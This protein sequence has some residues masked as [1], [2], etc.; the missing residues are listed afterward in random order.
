MVDLFEI[1]FDDAEKFLD[2]LRPSKK[3]WETSGWNKLWFFRGQS[4]PL[5][6]NGQERWKLIPSVWRSNP[7]F[8]D[9]RGYW[10]NDS[11]AVQYLYKR[12]Q[13][14]LFTKA[15]D[16]LNRVS[17]EFNIVDDFVKL[18]D[19][20]GF[21][22]PRLDEWIEYRKDLLMDYAKNILNDVTSK[23]WLHPIVALAQHHGIPTRLLDWTEN[24]FVA[25]Y[26]ALNSYEISK[27]DDKDINK[28][29]VVYAVNIYNLAD[30]FLL[31]LIPDMQK[32][33][34]LTLSK[35]ENQNLR[36]QEG[37]F[38]LYKNADK[39]FIQNGKFP[40]FNDVFRY[41]AT[42][43]QV[44]H[45]FDMDDNSEDFLLLLKYPYRKITLS[46]ENNEQIFELKRLLTHENYTQ[47]HLMPS[48]DNVASAVKSRLNIR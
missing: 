2:Y 18:A 39:Y 27:Q 41:N 26:F 30:D 35:A 13:D 11:Q 36:M 19:A 9:Y 43:L 29:I 16:L 40:N 6:E 47:A 28:Q 1:H 17:Y 22:L 33:Q 24:P 31:P 38:L 3:H 32:V 37:L 44:F 14:E 15:E 12:L 34:I 45:E 5:D 10:D 25:S 42:K 20:T 4:N 21:I 7:Q 8:L 23:I 46:V 48:L